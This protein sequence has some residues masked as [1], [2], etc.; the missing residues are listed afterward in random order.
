MWL[1]F[2]I[3]QMKKR[4]KAVNVS[5]FAVGHVFVGFVERVGSGIWNAEFATF[6]FCYLW[7]II[8]HLQYI[9]VS[10]FLKL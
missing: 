2:Y 8:S 10:L 3:N 9:F 4:E 5:L 6:F 7:K 1:W